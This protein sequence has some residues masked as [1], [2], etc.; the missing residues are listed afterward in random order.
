MVSFLI[1]KVANQPVLAQCF[2]PGDFVT[3]PA[4]SRFLH[5][6]KESLDCHLLPPLIDFA[7]NA[8]KN[9]QLATFL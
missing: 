9:C 5:K 4:A 2:A 8:P 3:P 1:L 7:Y 6:A